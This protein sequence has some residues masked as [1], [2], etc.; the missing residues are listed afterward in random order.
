MD[1]K[2]IKDF[3]KFI[4]SKDIEGSIIV[5]GDEKA[6][7]KE[8]IKQAY[9]IIH[10]FPEINI[11]EIDGESVTYD[12]IVNSCETL[13]FMFDKKLVHIKN[14]YFL[15]KSNSSPSAEISELLSKYIGNIPK[16]TIL[17][18]TINGEIDSRNKVVTAIKNIGTMVEYK[19][20]KGEELHKWVLDKLNRYGKT[21][22]K[23]DLMYLISESGGSTESLESEIEKLCAYTLNEDV[24]AKKHIDDIMYKSLES[25]IFKMVDSISRKDAEKALVILKNLLF[26]K[27]DHLRILGMIIRQYRMLY[28]VKQHIEQNISNSEMER[29]LKLSGFTLQNFIKQSKGYNGRELMKSLNKCLEIDYSIKIGKY[30]PEMA[31]ELLIIELCK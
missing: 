6:L 24:I 2:S 11:I 1:I 27:E 16:E 17:L 14:P 7:V 21:I 4:K 30:Q 9:E 12:A 28:L 15:L 3:I 26:Q 20:I 23:A 31:L 25:N 10:S 18:I 19:K 13:P 22:S 29:S 5:F 8:S